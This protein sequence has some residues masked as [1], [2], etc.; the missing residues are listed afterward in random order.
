[1]ALYA[2][3]S[4]LGLF[5]K[6]FGFEKSAWHPGTFLASFCTPKIIDKLMQKMKVLT[7]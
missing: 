6:S 5:L 2:K 1:M 7:F 4:D 3:F